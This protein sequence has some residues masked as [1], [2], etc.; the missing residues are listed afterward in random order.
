MICV[1][2]PSEVPT[3]ENSENLRFKV[4]KDFR[5]PIEVG[6]DLEN[7]QSKRFKVCKVFRLPIEVG[8]T[9]ENSQ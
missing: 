1:S 7:F 5:L 4:C 6:M 8:M 9:L 2:F 3:L